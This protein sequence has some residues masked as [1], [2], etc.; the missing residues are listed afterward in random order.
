M[1]SIPIIGFVG[2]VLA[3]GAVVVYMLKSRPL[4]PE[5]RKRINEEVW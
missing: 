1:N 3:A 5:E 2:L 4:T